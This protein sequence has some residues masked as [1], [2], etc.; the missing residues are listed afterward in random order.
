MFESQI[1]R[2]CMNGKTYSRFPTCFQKLLSFTGSG[3][4]K[5]GRMYTTCVW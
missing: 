1:I 3:D 4:S 2:Q 5:E